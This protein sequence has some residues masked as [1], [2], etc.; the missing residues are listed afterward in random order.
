[1]IEVVKEYIED[2]S[3]CYKGDRIRDHII[4]GTFP[5]RVVEIAFYEDDERIGEFC[6]ECRRDFTVKARI[7]QRMKAIYGYCCCYACHMRHERHN[8]KLHE[9]RVLAYISNY[10]TAF[11]DEDLTA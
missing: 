8:K 4:P 7:W 3:P 5:R 11:L 2:I 9:A 6:P 10:R 1:M